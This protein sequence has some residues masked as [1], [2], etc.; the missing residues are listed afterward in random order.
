MRFTSRTSAFVYI[1]L[2]LFVFR[3]KMFDLKNKC[4]CVRA[5]GFVFF[6]IEMI[7]LKNKYLC[8]IARLSLN[9]MS[10]VIG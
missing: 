8:Y 6:R 4:L 2:V 10:T 5:F 3:I 9:E 7:D 1:L